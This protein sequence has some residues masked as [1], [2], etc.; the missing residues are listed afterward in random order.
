[1]CSGRPSVLRS[2]SQVGRRLNRQCSGLWS[3]KF[4]SRLWTLRTL[5]VKR[6]LALLR[7]V[8]RAFVSMDSLGWKNIAGPCSW[9]LRALD[10]DPSL[11]LVHGLVLKWARGGAPK[12]DGEGVAQRQRKREKITQP[13]GIKVLLIGFGWVGEKSPSSSPSQVSQCLCS[14]GIMY[15][16]T[17]QVLS[18]WLIRWRCG[19]DL[20]ASQGNICNPPA[21]NHTFPISLPLFRGIKLVNYCRWI[22]ACAAVHLAIILVLV[23]NHSFHTWFK[24]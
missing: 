13:L 16:E 2:K 18:G 23:D 15:S 7:L 20:N 5:R 24:A 21:G 4:W 22:T 3:V 6:R 10:Q 9:F 17:S 11:R 8:S 19:G 1:M 14:C 12:Q